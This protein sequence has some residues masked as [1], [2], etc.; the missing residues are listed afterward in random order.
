MDAP[1]QL[2]RH[3]V[4]HHMEWMRW[5]LNTDTATVSYQRLPPIQP[6]LIRS[7][8]PSCQVLPLRIQVDHLK[9]P[10]N[11]D[12]NHLVTTDTPHYLNFHHGSKAP[13]L[14][15]PRGILQSS[16]SPLHR[17]KIPYSAVGLMSTVRSDPGA[18]SQPQCQSNPTSLGEN[19]KGTRRPKATGCRDSQQ[20]RYTIPA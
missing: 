11:C 20:H 12:P 13:L 5:Q 8:L 14:V 7:K 15:V 10:L 3:D 9:C 19:A 16:S 17:L 2:R 1:L 6:A 4:S 18:P